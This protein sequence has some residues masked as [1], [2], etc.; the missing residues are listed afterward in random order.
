M[1]KVA[2]VFSSVWMDLTGEQVAD[3]LRQLLDGT[4][5]TEK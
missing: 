2:S 3:N 4:L 1:Q 5:T